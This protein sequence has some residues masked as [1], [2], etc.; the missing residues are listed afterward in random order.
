MYYATQWKFISFKEL[1][2]MTVTS[3]KMNE[4]CWHSNTE[5]E[6]LMW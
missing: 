1:S 6:N 2:H 4:G 5:G 3:P